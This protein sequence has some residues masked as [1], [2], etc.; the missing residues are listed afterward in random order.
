MLSFQ[1]FPQ[2]GLN[3]KA[4]NEEKEDPNPHDQEDHVLKEGLRQIVDDG[5]GGGVKDPIVV[6]KGQLM[7]EDKGSVKEK[8]QGE[9]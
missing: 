1:F 4:E 8:D 2:I 7:E 5:V 6:G 9:T 3:P